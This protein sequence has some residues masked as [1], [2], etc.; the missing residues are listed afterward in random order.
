MENGNLGEKTS[1]MAFEHQ[2]AVCFMGI[3]LIFNFFLTTKTN[4]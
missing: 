4:D 1:E 3:F 2:V